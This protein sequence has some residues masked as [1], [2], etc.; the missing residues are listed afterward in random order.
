V[1]VYDTDGAVQAVQ[2]IIDLEVERWSGASD[3][4]V[5]T[6][7]I[8]VPSGSEIKRGWYVVHNGQG[9]QVRDRM[10]DDGQLME[11]ELRRVNIGFGSTL[12]A[13][14]DMTL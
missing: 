2:A 7:T 8:T 14:L 6:D 12:D 13:S 3:A 11:L 1:D 10:S 9:W 5:N 4:V